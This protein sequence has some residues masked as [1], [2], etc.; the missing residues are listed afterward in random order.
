MDEM[1]A[2]LLLPMQRDI[3]EKASSPPVGDAKLIFDTLSH[4]TI[5]SRADRR[6]AIELTIVRD[7]MITLDF[8]SAGFRMGDARRTQD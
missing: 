4:N 3:G 5:G 2:L 8:W 7:A 6:N 1:D